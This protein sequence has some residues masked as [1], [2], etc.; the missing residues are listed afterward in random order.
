MSASETTYLRLIEL[1]FNKI[2]TLKEELLAE[3]LKRKKEFEKTLDEFDKTV[4]HKPNPYIKKPQW[5]WGDN[6]KTK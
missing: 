4:G 1:L 6:T 5:Y 3:K 2:D